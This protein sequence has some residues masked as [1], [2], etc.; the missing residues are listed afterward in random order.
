MIGV[1]T[2]VLVRLA[3]RDDPKQSEIAE[4]FFGARSANDPAFISLA[5]LIE[6]VW[7]L[8]RRYRADF[9]TISRLIRGL[10]GSGE[11]VVQASDVVRRAL[12]FAVETGADFS[13]AVLAI[14][15]VD[16]D[17]DY[18]VTFDRRAADLPGMRLLE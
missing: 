2:N 5:V 3:V 12:D 18:T 11:A 8:D 13:D 15:G 16:S 14:L 7:V 17:C 4:R 10:L 1:D 6:T 9:D